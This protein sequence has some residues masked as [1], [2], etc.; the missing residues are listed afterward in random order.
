MAQYLAV[1]MGFTERAVAER[2]D[3]SKRATSAKT[4][5]YSESSAWIE[6][7]SVE[8]RFFAMPRSSMFQ[9]TGKLELAAWA[10]RPHISWV[11]GCCLRHAGQPNIKADYQPLRPGHSRG[12]SRAVTSAFMGGSPI[13]LSPAQDN[14]Y[15]TAPGEPAPRMALGRRARAGRYCRVINFGR[16]KTTSEDDRGRTS[17]RP[18]GLFSCAWQLSPARG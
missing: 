9:A 11:I 14:R 13:G 16:D 3:S 4:V 2:A 1:M 12:D 8:L 7:R 10:G 5:S 17:T 6:T 15:H 18:L